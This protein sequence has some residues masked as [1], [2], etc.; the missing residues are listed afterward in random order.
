M[1]HPKST[2]AI[3]LA[4]LMLLAVSAAQAAEAGGPDLIWGSYLAGSGFDE[5]C[6]VALDASGNAWIVGSTGSSDFPTPGG[7][8]TTVGGGGTYN[9]DVFVAKITPTGALAW[10]T[11]LGGTSEDRGQ[12]LAIDRM[13]NVWLTGYTNSDD[14]PVSQAFESSRGGDYDAFVAVVTPSGT[15]A[16]ARYLGGTDSDYGYGIA[17]DA[18]GSAWVT[19]AAESDDF[20]V[21]GGFQ[22][23]YGGNS[24]AFVARITKTGDLAWA[25]YYGGSNDD[26]TFAIAIDSTGSVWVTGYS[27]SPDLAT[28]GGFDTTLDGHS[29]PFA[30]RVTRSGTLAWA[31][32]LGGTDHGNGAAIAI[33]ASGNAWVAGSTCSADFPTPGGFQTEY[34]GGLQDGFIARIT[35][36]GT[37]SM[38]TYLGGAADDYC[39]GIDID[40][41]GDVWVTGLTASSDMST[42]EGLHTVFGGDYDAFVARLAPSGTPRWVSYVGGDGNDSGYGIATDAWSKI[43]VTGRTTSLDFP[44]PGGFQTDWAGGADA[45]AAKITPHAPEEVNWLEITKFQMGLPAAHGRDS[46]V[47]QAA[48]NMWPGGAPPTVTLRLDSTWSLVVD[49]ASWKRNGKSNVYTAKQA[50]VTCKM[51]LWV[52]GTSKCLLQFS[53]SRQTLQ[54]ALTD[55]AS[56]PVRLQIGPWFDETVTA[57][58]TLKNH[59][60]RLKSRGP[61]PLFYPEKLTVTRNKRLSGRDALSLSGKLFLSEDFDVFNDSVTAVV[62]PYE[63]S[64]PA[65][66]SAKKGAVS[67]VA[68]E[69]YGSALTLE[70]NGITH[71]LKITAT[72]VDLSAMSQ[73]VQIALSITNHPGAAWRYWVFASK[74]KARTL[75][76][77]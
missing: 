37:L 32:Y 23:T 50:G 30:V 42:S 69:A 67:Y 64:F 25:S 58:M 19:G 53:G 65:S 17:I 57:A 20:P 13:G 11:Y 33:D 29:E 8:Q 68:A 51:T 48:C 35:P 62:G 52:G 31:S 24:D 7:F 21:P 77:Y 38:A 12:A 34:G 75:Y 72:N 71:V 18:S 16:W 15:L 46:L 22:T 66:E 39:C 1:C 49:A 56:V 27:Y 14:F 45:F 76:K 2:I 59:V 44:T 61:L 6:A 5:G 4:F 28:P 73:D 74:N 47:L 70:L 55:P 9:G 40:P 43:W 36:Q 3:V 41:S 10:A 60:A 63:M 26:E 54:G